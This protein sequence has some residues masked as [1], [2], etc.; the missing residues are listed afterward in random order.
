MRKLEPTPL[1]LNFN[2]LNEKTSIIEL[3]SKTIIVQIENEFSFT[4]LSVD[5]IYEE[6]DDQY[7]GTEDA[8]LVFSYLVINSHMGQR[9]LEKVWNKNIIGVSVPHHGFISKLYELIHEAF[10]NN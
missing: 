5:K 4:Y 3:K 9:E 6:V 1:C 2:Y 7:A 8:T 10:L